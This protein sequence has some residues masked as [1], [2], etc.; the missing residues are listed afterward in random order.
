MAPH[1]KLLLPVGG[2]PLVRR[3]AAAA[4]EAELAPVVAVTGH[5]RD[6][7]A[8]TLRGLP[9]ALAH[10]DGHAEGIASSLRIG[11][12]VLPPT[13]DAAVILLGDKPRIEAR[14]LRAL[15]AAFAPEQGVGACVPCWQGRRGNPVLWGRAHFPELLALR[16]DR[17][18]REL[19]ERHAARV[20]ELEMPDDAVLHDVDDA[21]A[22]ESLR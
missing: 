6:A 3:V 13:A 8:A 22:W 21:A 12:G 7:V 15:A 1:N 16:G 19:L 11:I 17:G 4:L 20:R 2:E 18:A 10:N 9:V 5:D 14:H